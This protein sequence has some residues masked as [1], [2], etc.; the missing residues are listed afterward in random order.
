M[1]SIKARLILFKA[2]GKN[3]SGLLLQYR[4]IRRNAN[5]LLLEVKRTKCRLKGVK[6]LIFEFLPT[7]CK[8]ENFKKQKRS[9]Q[10]I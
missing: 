3:T 7:L 6:M 8:G 5:G 1:R 4:Y 9:L 10:K 2:H